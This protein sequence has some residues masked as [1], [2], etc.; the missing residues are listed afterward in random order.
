M[1]ISV[2]DLVISLPVVLIIFL[3]IVFPLILSINYKL[4]K[5]SRKM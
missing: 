1:I 3:G 5:I 2:S 4:F